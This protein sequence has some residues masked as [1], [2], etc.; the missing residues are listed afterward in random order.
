[1][2]LRQIIY[3][4][5]LFLTGH[6]LYGQNIQGY[7]DYEKVVVILPEYGKEQ[8]A[9]EIKRKQLSD[10]I[11]IMIKKFQRVLEQSPHNVKMDS[12]SKASLEATLIEFQKKITD[13]QNHAQTEHNQK[14]T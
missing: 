3:I 11:A 14:V 1:M 7:I 5:G 12:A 6:I 4:F 8:S 10:S 2:T 9:L 13:A